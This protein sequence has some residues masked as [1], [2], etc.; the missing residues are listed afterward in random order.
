MVQ[1]PTQMKKLTILRHAKAEL[2]E[3][4]PSDFVRPLTKR[5]EK[6]AALIAAFLA[7]L[8]PPIDWILSSPALRAEQTTKAVAKRLAKNVPAVYEAQIYEADA[9]LL[10][11]LLK[12]I[13]P[14]PEHVLLIGHNPSLESFVAG[15]CTGSPG[16]LECRLATAAMAHLDMEIMRWDQIRWGSGVLQLLLQPRLLRKG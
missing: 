12:A 14:E 7:Q 8:D 13:P 9:G 5:G 3:K 15:L 6:D 11:N 1:E 16:N 10:L 2:P 4:Y